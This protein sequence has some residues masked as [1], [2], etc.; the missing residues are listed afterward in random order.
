MGSLALA[1]RRRADP[2]VYRARPPAGRDSRVAVPDGDA[3]RDRRPLDGGP[4]GGGYAL[5]HSD[6]GRDSHR[7]D[8]HEV[9]ARRRTGR[10]APDH[11]ATGEP[12]VARDAG[13]GAPAPD[14]R[15]RDWSRDSARARER[16]GGGLARLL[17]LEDAEQPRTA[18]KPGV[19]AAAVG[20]DV[21]MDGVPGLLDQVDLEGKP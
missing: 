21:N 18:T 12:P 19:A 4:R 3:E 6:G 8:A 13:Q 1:A 16:S 2:G 14:S 9:R 7:P 10:G 11:T 15:S 20:V 17:T 5:R